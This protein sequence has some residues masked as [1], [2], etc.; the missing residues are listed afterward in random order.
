[1]TAYYTGGADELDASSAT[2]TVSKTVAPV[3]GDSIAVGDKVRVKITVSGIGLKRSVDIRDYIP[4]GFRFSE[5]DRDASANAW[6]CDTDGQRVTICA[7]SSGGTTATAVF[8]VRAVTEGTFAVNSAY[9]CDS[10]SNWGF[11]ERSTVTV[12]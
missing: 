2:Y 12:G 4:S 9:A 11:S 8:Y 6:L 1:M 3:R 10:E 5:Y 7:Y